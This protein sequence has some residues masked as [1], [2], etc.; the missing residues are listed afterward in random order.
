MNINSI[1]LDLPIKLDDIFYFSFNFDGLK[2]IID[3]FQ[4][5]NSLLISTI[6][7]FNKRMLACESLKSDIDD[8]KIKSINI[9]KTMKI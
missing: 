2:K 9:E 3:F 4:K 7:D 8:I 1:C 6:K 5:N